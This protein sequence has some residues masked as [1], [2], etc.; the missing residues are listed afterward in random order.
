MSAAELNRTRTA[1]EPDR[2]ARPMIWIASDN[3][4]ATATIPATEQIAADQLA[5]LQ[6]TSGSTSDP[7]GVMVSH[8]NFL[9]NLESIRG[10]LGSPYPGDDLNSVSWLPLH[11][12]MGL[13]GVALATV[14]FGGSADLM[15]PA[16]FV[17]QPIRWLQLISSRRN[18]CTSAPNFAFD[19]CIDATTAQQRAE[20][21]LSGWRAALCGAEFVR[22]DTMKRFVEVFAPNGFDPDALRPVYGLAEA[23]LLVTGSARSGGPLSKWLRRRDLHERR[24]VEV[25]PD[26]DSATAMVA[27]GHAQPGTTLI[28]VDPDTRRP[29]PAGVVGEIWITSDAVAQGYWNNDVA[30]TAAFEATIDGGTGAQYLRTGDLGFL[31]GDELF[32]VA[33][34]KDLIIIRGRNL[35]PDDI[36]ATVQGI[37]RVLLRG[38]GAAFS[39]DAADGEHLVIV[40]EVDRDVPPD[41]DLISVCAEV[42]TTVMQ[43]YEVAVSDVLLVG[44]YRLPS[45]SSG[46]VQ[47]FACR[48]K[49]VA[50]THE[51]VAG[52]SRPQSWETGTVPPASRPAAARPTV[53]ELEAWLMSYLA[54]ELRIAVGEIDPGQPFAY[55]G[56]DSIR[57]VELA[58]ALSAFV[59]TELRPTIAYEF[60]SIAELATHVGSVKLPAPQKLTNARM[61]G[62][63]EPIAV[64]GMACRFPGADGLHAFWTL[65]RDGGDAISEVPSDRW[66]ADALYDPEGRRPGAMNTKWGGFIPD[67]DRFDREFFG[68]SPREAEQMDPQQRLLL[69]TSWEALDNAGIPPRSLSRSAT[70]VFVG[71]SSYDYALLLSMTGDADSPY[72]AT[73]NAGSIAANRLSYFLDFVGPSVAVDTACSSSLVAVHLACKSLHHGESELALAAGVNVILSPTVNTSFSRAGITSPDGRCKAFD[74][75]ANGIVRSEGVGVVV[76][77]PLSRAIEHGDHVYALVRGGATNQ[78]GRSN[79][80]TAPRL[81]SQVAVLEAAYRDAGVSPADVS[82]VEAHGTGTPLGDP[83]E[84]EALGRVL[85][86]GRPAG[87]RCRLGSVKTNL[88]HLEAAAGVAG[89]IKL[90]LAL[91]RHELPASLH[92][93]SPNPHIDFEALG[94]VV[95]AQHADW[96]SSDRPRIAGVSSFGFGGTNAHLVVSEY[97]MSREIRSLPNGVSP[98][99]TGVLPLSAR[100]REG[101]RTL[102]GRYREYLEANPGIATDDLCYTAGARRSHH[103]CRVAVPFSS[104]AGLLDALHRLNDDATQCAAV[105]VGRSPRIAFVFSGQGSQWAGMGRRLAEC[106]PGFGHHLEACAAAI[107]RHAGWSLFDE[108]SVESGV[109]LEQVTS[110]VQPVLFAYQIALA[111]LIQSWGIEAAAVVGHSMGEIAA[112]HIAG[113]LELDDAV[114]I[115][116]RRSQL[117]DATKGLGGMASLE[118]SVADATRR[119][120]PYGSRLSIAAVNGPKETIV[121][122]DVSALDR[123]GA[124]VLADELFFRRLKVDV[125]GHCAQVEPYAHELVDFLEGLTPATGSLPFFSTVDAD[126]LGGQRLDP[127]YWGRNLREPVRFHPTIERMLELGYHTFLEIAPHPVLTASMHQIVEHPTRAGRRAVITSIRRGDELHALRDCQAALYE[128]GADLHWD[129]VFPEGRHLTSL[130]SYPWEQQRCWSSRPRGLRTYD[131]RGS[132]P[133]VHPLLGVEHS[134]AAAPGRVWENVIFAG[135]PSYLADHRVEGAPIFPA[136][137]YVELALHAASLDG[138]SDGTEHDATIALRDIQFEAPL[139]LT[140]AVEVQSTQCGDELFVGRRDAADERTAWRRHARMHVD[141]ASEISPPIEGLEELRA[142]C[143]CAVDVED[144]YRGAHERG[145]E[146]GP[147]FRRIRELYRGERAALARIDTRGAPAGHVVYPGVLDSA[148]QVLGAA[149]EPSSIG[150]Q[151]VLPVRIGAVVCHGSISDDGDVWCFAELE[152]SGDSSEIRGTLRGGGTYYGHPLACATAVASIHAFEDEGIL[153]HVRRLGDEVIG[154]GL[155]TLGQRHPSVGDVRGIGCF[156]VLELVED[157]V[158]RTPLGPSSAPSGNANPMQELERLCLDRGVAV[159]VVGNRVHVCPPL[160][161]ISDDDVRHGL[162]VLDEALAVADRYSRSGGANAPDLGRGRN[163]LRLG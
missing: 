163:P 160:I 132:A 51:V 31:E 142:R 103:A 62:T 131:P 90:V 130:P 53:G 123:L 1:I 20:L 44:A 70:G 28:I 48:E 55:Y 9:H 98:A 82:Y 100:S 89:L 143:S 71:I 148:L 43:E 52:W 92:F 99:A 69:Q 151:L 81:G 46:K 7:K 159:L 35:Y 154:P 93:E 4:P 128:A 91:D 60:P 95:Q 13:V 68:I 12:D 124:D 47:R 29:C 109:R 158:S 129:T 36:E 21:D 32:V 105:D 135:R 144:F 86:K 77:E 161:I 139:V 76:L 96:V 127:D 111:K 42:A 104:K 157:R 84:C 140:D 94:L 79:G 149:V 5:L 34:L 11:H 64:V 27:C 26:D 40:Q 147:E 102:A 153:A 97:P 118:L 121:S 101:L 145:L 56:V 73:G 125:A 49:F 2:P 75:R 155:R 146:Y 78:D 19:L 14:Y 67:V 57:A 116:C 85:S 17:L 33:R 80:L 112:A 41:T 37:H 141:V 107:E 119:I 23:T 115:I 10:V 113:A 156:W 137:G 3:L 152:Q 138:D 108:L 8:R 74:S 61:I 6:Y 106:V 59:G 87:D 72:V 63:D 88:G 54:G 83:I 25:N 16:S 18:V 24:V 136:V 39:V 117:I 65:L 114:R 15:S 45:T 120:A 50:G 134:L 66:D 38:R 150:S 126:E 22:P 162:S 58:A 122:G 30:T 110:V 133:T